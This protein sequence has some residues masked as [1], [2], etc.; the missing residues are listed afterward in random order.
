M[1]SIPVGIP[2]PGVFWDTALRSW[3]V[4]N[5]K[6]VSGKAFNRLRQQL[7]DVQLGQLPEVGEKHAKGYRF[8]LGKDA[9]GGFG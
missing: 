7:A 2:I 9:K 3:L 6:L 8:R 4:S 5:T 1:G